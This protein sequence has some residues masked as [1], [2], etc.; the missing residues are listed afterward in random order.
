MIR[1][2]NEGLSEEKCISGRVVYPQDDRMARQTDS[3]VLPHVTATIRVYGAVKVRVKLS[4][5]VTVYEKKGRK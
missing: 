2:I 1:E 5:F 3:A 4:A